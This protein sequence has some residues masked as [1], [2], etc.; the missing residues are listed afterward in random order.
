MQQ[1]PYRIAASNLLCKCHSLDIIFKGKRKEDTMGL[2][3]SINILAVSAAFL[4]IAAM[5][6]V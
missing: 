1:Q 4:F 2:T 6:F 5:L 3:R